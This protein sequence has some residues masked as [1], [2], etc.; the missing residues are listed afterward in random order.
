M[1]DRLTH[2]STRGGASRS[3]VVIDDPSPCPSPRW[4]WPCAA[5]EC[6]AG[7][8]G[9]PPGSP[10]VLRSGMM[11]AL[12]SLYWLRSLRP[13]AGLGLRTQPSR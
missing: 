3:E 5:G 1:R 4:R 12:R 8:A 11:A 13:T 9:L 7:E 6:E 2:G 10:S